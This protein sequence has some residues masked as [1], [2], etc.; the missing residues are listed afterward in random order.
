MTLSGVDGEKDMSHRH[1][2]HP[3]EQPDEDGC[4]PN[5]EPS[6][7]FYVQKGKTLSLD[8]IVRQYCQGRI[9]SPLTK[10]GPSLVMME[11]SNLY[12]VLGLF[13]ALQYDVELFNSAN[14]QG[15][16]VSEQQYTSFRLYR[17]A[18]RMGVRL[19]LP[20][21]QSD[22]PVVIP[23]LDALVSYL[24][25]EH[26]QELQHATTTLQEGIV[27]FDSLM[28]YFRPGTDLVDSGLLTG[29]SA[30]TLV[31]CRASYYRRGK[32]AL[33]NPVAT[34]HAA[35]EFVVAV[36]G[37]KFAIVE[38]SMFQSE[39]EGT[40]RVEI[41][42]TLSNS[43]NE[44]LTR[45]SPAILEV[46]KE[47]GQRYEEFAVDDDNR[48]G[49]GHLV[50]Y[51]AG[52][53]WPLSL[54]TSSHR[55]AHGGRPLRTSGRMMVDTTEGWARGI[56]AAKAPADGMA[57]DAV[58][59]GF[60]VAARMR[61]QHEQE[62]A[63]SKGDSSVQN[64][65]EDNSIDGD[66]LLV[67]SP[68][69]DS[70]IR[71]TWPVVCGFSL[72]SRTWGLA[73]V[74]GL[75]PVVFQESAF[76]ALVLPQARKRLLRALVTSHNQRK[77]ARSADILPGKGEG[78]IFLLHGPSGVGKTLTAE[79]VSEVLHRP[80]YRVSMGELGTTPESLEERL[81]A[82]FDLCL[83]WQALILI[84]EAEMLLETRQNSNN[85]IRNAM[86]CVM[87]RLLEYYPGIL[88]LTTNS[89]LECLDPAI[90]SRLTCTLRYEALDIKGRMKIWNAT[91]DRVGRDEE[92]TDVSISE[93]DIE[94]LARDYKGI[95]GRQIKNA[96]QL[97]S[98]LC[99]YEKTPMTTAH[100]IEMLEMTTSMVR[101]AD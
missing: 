62:R 45:P 16:P 20:W 82:I 84:D 36:G 53:F 44:I 38:A 77:G 42:D 58:L 78:I 89:G 57:S 33:G 12:D 21:K 32:S 24:E 37:N 88:F 9:Q 52:T 5:K 94:R 100:L 96:V 55:G 48:R 11:T 76:D 49:S 51:Q 69:P 79:A 85:L 17:Q 92:S 15:M 87:L 83:P 93:R 14:N 2:W 81:Q 7:I 46:L 95:N 74:D 4:P 59:D 26:W 19:P 28:E 8:V 29:M 10:G 64:P 18:V 90:A 75:S 40:R 86:V 101:D 98:S 66:V 22:D 70:L 31:R 73:L 27:D 72:E 1:I 13:R 23:G 56:H 65:M 39:F 34:F 6:C 50:T 25:A 30:T 63:S 71:R 35:L 47:R 91:L 80:L 43:S 67:E 99:H 41:L 54:T 61:R 3:F 97:A 60:K 68:L